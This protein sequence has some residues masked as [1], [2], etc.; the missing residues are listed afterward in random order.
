[1]SAD[2]RLGLTLMLIAQDAFCFPKPQEVAPINAFP[3]F[4]DH[5]NATYHMML[6]HKDLKMRSPIKNAKIFSISNIKIC[7]ID[8][9]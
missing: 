6:L 9:L 3:T 4:Q 2:T 5:L 8:L 1:M 7:H